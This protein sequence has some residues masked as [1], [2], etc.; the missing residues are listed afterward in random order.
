MK[1]QVL[2]FLIMLFVLTLSVVPL[3]AQV[4]RD[5]TGSTF[6]VDLT[7]W[8]PGSNTWIFTV[9][10]PDADLDGQGIDYIEVDFPVDVDVTT[11]T[12]FV[13]SVLPEVIPSDGTIGSTGITIKW[14]GADVIPPGG[15][16]TATI[17]A[18]IPPTFSGSLPLAWSVQGEAGYPVDPQ[19]IN[20]VVAL[21]Q[22]PGITNTN[23]VITT[24]TEGVDATT[25]IIGSEVVVTA[26]VTGEKAV[27]GVWV[28]MTAF[29]LGAIE[30]LSISRDGTYSGTFNVV[31]G[32][33]DAIDVQV[34]FS[35]ENST[36]E[37]AN[38]TDAGLFVV[39][40][41][42]PNFAGTGPVITMTG[43]DAIASI[44]D[45]LTFDTA[46]ATVV[47]TDAVEWDVAWAALTGS[48]GNVADGGSVDGAVIAGAVASS[49]NPNITATDDAGNTFTLTYG[50]IDADN[51]PPNVS[52]WGTF[53]LVNKDGSDTNTFAD[54]NNGT[55][56][57]DVTYAIGTVSSVA[58]GETWAVDY[59]GQFSGT[60]DP[61]GTVI[62]GTM[63]GEEWTPTIVVTDDAGNTNSNPNFPSG[64]L[65]D[66]QIPTASAIT[67]EVLRG[68]RA[69][70]T[71]TIGE[72]IRATVDITGMDVV[73]GTFDFWMLDPLAG[74]V[75]TNPAYIINGTVTATTIYAD[76]T[77]M[78]GD[79][80]IF[81]A[82]GVGV[83]VTLVDSADNSASM[84]LFGGVGNELYV[85][86]T[87]PGILDDLAIPS[88]DQYLRF[89]PESAVVGT[90]TDTPDVLNLTVGLENWGEPG[91]ASRFQL[92]IEAEDTREVV[93]Y[94][95]YLVADV[96]EAIPNEVT[97]SWDGMHPTTGL[98]LPNG[99]Y[100]L[101]LWQVTDNGSLNGVQGYVATIG[102]VDL[103]M[104]IVQLNAVHCVIDNAAP[105]YYDELAINAAGT[106]TPK[107][108]IERYFNDLNGNDIIDPGET[109]PIIGDYD[110]QF[111]FGIT[112]EFTQN[113]NP[114][115]IENLEYW[116]TV[117]GG[118]T[119]YF[120]DGAGIDGTP[121]FDQTADPVLIN[122]SAPHDVNAYVGNGGEI[123]WEPVD[124]ILWPAGDYT[125]TAYVQDTAGNIA[126]SAGRT[127]V[128]IT[129]VLYHQPILTN[130]EIISQHD[131]G[132]DPFTPM[133]AGDHNFYLNSN[134]TAVPNDQYYNT[135]DI[136]TV[137]ITFDD[138]EYLESVTINDDYGFGF[139]NLTFLPADFVGN[140][141]TVD[142]DVSTIDEGDAGSAYNFIDGAPLNGFE[143]IAR[144]EYLAAPIPPSGIEDLFNL[145]RPIEPV[146]P[147]AANFTLSMT[148]DRFSPGWYTHVY[149][150]Q[151]N[152]ATDGTLDETGIDFSMNFTGGLT[153]D[154]EW[155]LAVD[156][157][158]ID[159]PSRSAFSA[160]EFV[161]SGTVLSGGGPIVETIPTINFVGLKDDV[162][163][164]P[165]VGALDTAPLYVSAFATVVGD[166]SDTGYIV[167]PPGFT[168]TI[169]TKE[170]WVDNTNPELL[171][172]DGSALIDW[173][174]DANYAGHL[175]SEELVVSSSQD[176]LTIRFQTSEPIDTTDLSGVLTDYDGNNIPV[177][178]IITVTALDAEVTENGVTGH[179]HFAAFLDANGTIPAGTE[180]LEA[181]I[182][183]MI[184][185][186]SAGNPG[187]VNNPPY[188]FD[189]VAPYHAGSDA[190]RW[191]SSE[192]Y[193]RVM[194]LS[195]VPYIK[196]VRW[197]HENSYGRVIDNGNLT[198]EGYVSDSGT[199]T[200]TARINN[201]DYFPLEVGDRDITSIID[202]DFSIF[203][204]ESYENSATA[205]LM[206]SGHDLLV[207]WTD[208]PF[209]NIGALGDGT[210]IN[211]PF[212]LGLVFTA[213]E[214]GHYYNDHLELPLT[215]DIT[216]PVVNILDPVFVARRDV[217]L[218]EGST[219][220][221]PVEIIDNGSGVW[222]SVPPMTLT[223]DYS[224][225]GTLTITYD[226]YVA[227]DTYNWTVVVPENTDIRTVV[228]T[229]E[230]TDNVANL[231]TDIS[232]W[233]VG[234]V[235]LLEV[236]GFENTNPL[237]PNFIKNGDDAVLYISVRDIERVS[238]IDISLN[239]EFVYPV[240][241]AGYAATEVLTLTNAEFLA[242]PDAMIAVPARVD[243]NWEFKELLLGSINNAATL[244]DCDPVV[245]TVTINHEYDDATNA[246]FTTELSDES[247]LTVDN[248]PAT[249]TNITYDLA[250]INADAGTITFK[251]EIADM[252]EACP[253]GLDESTINLDLTGVNGDAVNAPDD[254]TLAGLAT[255][256]FAWPGDFDTNA[257]AIASALVDIDGIV[258]VSVDDNLGNSNSED[259][260][261]DTKPVITDV[262]WFVNN[263]ETDVILP[264]NQ[265]DIRVEVTVEGTDN[266]LEYKIGDRIYMEYIGA[267]L[268]TPITFGTPTQVVSSRDESVTFAFS[269]T[270]AFTA[271]M[272]ETG[273][274]TAEF[275]T[276]ALSMYNFRSDDVENQVVVSDYPREDLYGVE[277]VRAQD[278]YDGNDPTGWFA[279]EHNIRGEMTFYTVIEYGTTDV[280]ANFDYVGDFVSPWINPDVVNTVATEDI[281]LNPGTPFEVTITMLTQTAIWNEIVTDAQS[282]WNLII[283]AGMGYVNEGNVMDGFSLPIDMKAN[284]FGF[285]MDLPTKY[286]RVDLNDPAYS[287]ADGSEYYLEEDSRDFVPEVMAADDSFD[288]GLS[289]FQEDGLRAIVL[290][291][292]N[293][294]SS[295]WDPVTKTYTVELP[296][297]DLPFTQDFVLTTYA[298]DW[299]ST[300][301]YPSLGGVSPMTIE[302]PTSADFTIAPYAADEF[303]YLNNVSPNP[304]DQI[305]YANWVLTP[306][307]GGF[308]HGDE[309]TVQLGTITD[310][311][312]HNGGATPEFTFVFSAEYQNLNTDDLVIYKYISDSEPENA[313]IAPYVQAGAEFGIKLPV[314]SL[315]RDT[316][317]SGVDVFTAM[318]ENDVADTAAADLV[319]GSWWKNLTASSTEAGV[320][321]LDQQFS[322]YVIAPT[323]A[324]GSVLNVKLRVNYVNGSVQETGW[325]T[326]RTENHAI[327]DAIAP[328]I[329][330]Y[331]IEIWSETLTDADGTI[332][333]GYVVPGDNDATLKITFEDNTMMYP[334]GA[335]PL[336]EVAGLDQFITHYWIA[337]NDEDGF[338]EHIVMPALFTVPAEYITAQRGTWIAEIPRL[339][340]NPTNPVA[341]QEEILVSLW[342]AVGNAFIG[343]A[344]SKF[345]EITADGPIV[346]VIKGM[347]VIAGTP[348]DTDVDYTAFVPAADM[349]FDASGL[350]FNIAEGEDAP[351]YIN[352]YVRAKYKAYIE[353]MW[354]DLGN[355]GGD[356]V[357][358][359][360]PTEI[361]AVIDPVNNPDD[362]LW[363]ATYMMPNP[364]LSRATDVTITA[365]TLR[366]PF[367]A[368]DVFTDE[369]EVTLHVDQLDVVNSSLVVANNVPDFEV[370]WTFDPDFGFTV[371][372]EFDNI[373]GEFGYGQPN[374]SVWNI[375]RAQVQD[376]FYLQ[377][378][379]TDDLF[380]NDNAIEPK[381]S[382]IEFIGVNDTDAIPSII[383]N[384]D[385]VR[386]TW[387]IETADL[388]PDWADN[389]LY[390]AEDTAVNFDVHFRNIYGEWL[391][392]N[393]VDFNAAGILVDD[394]DPIFID[395]YTYG[396]NHQAN[397]TIVPDQDSNVYV[398]LE[399]TD[400]N[401][402]KYVTS[403]W[404][405]FDGAAALQMD[406]PVRAE[407]DFVIGYGPDVFN[408]DPVSMNGDVYITLTDNVGNVTSLPGDAVNTTFVFDEDETFSAY[409]YPDGSMI[410]SGGQ[411]FMQA[412]EMQ[413]FIEHDI[414]QHGSIQGFAP[415]ELEFEGIDNDGDF[416]TDEPGEGLVYDPALTI[417]VNSHVDNNWFE[418][419][420][421]LVDAA[422]TT[423]IELQG[424]FADLTEGAY[425]IHVNTDNIFGHNLD[426]TV[427]FFVDQTAPRVA[428]IRFQTGGTLSVPYAMNDVIIS[429]TD[430]DAIL[431]TFEDV[432]LADARDMVQPG[433][434]LDT[435][436]SSVVLEGPEGVI[437]G[438][439]VMSWNGNVAALTI[440]ADRWAGINLPSGDYTLTMVATDLLGNSATYTKTF[441]YNYT[442]AEVTLHIFDDNH[443]ELGAGDVIELSEEVAYI[444]A[445]VNDE[446][447]MVTDV[448][449]QLYF[450]VN[451]DNVLGPEDMEYT[452]IAG[453][454][455]FEV[456]FESTWNL[457][458]DDMTGAELIEHMNVYNYRHDEDTFN[459]NTRDWFIVTT[460][461][462]NSGQVAET[463]TTVMVRDNVG[464]AP[465]MLEIVPMRGM[466]QVES[467]VYN[468]TYNYD[469]M[470]DNTADL[471]SICKYDDDADG[472]VPDMGD[473]D[474][475][476][477]WYVNYHITGP[478]GYDVTI[479][480]SYMQPAAHTYNSIWNWG[481]LAVDNPGQYLITVTGHDRVGNSAD[482]LNSFVVNLATVG[483]AWSELAMTNFDVPNWDLTNPIVHGSEFG[484]VN[485]IQNIHN[486]R[487]DAV[488]HEM[489]EVVS[490]GFYYDVIDNVTGLEVSTMNP[491][492]NDP[493]INPDFGT[494]LTNILPQEVNIVGNEGTLRVVVDE[495]QYR[496]VGY[497]ANDYS[498]KFYI[499]ITD[500]SGVPFIHGDSNVVGFRVDYVA[501]AANM[502]AIDEVLTGVIDNVTVVVP[503][504]GNAA[505]EFGF[506]YDFV[507]LDHILNFKWSYDGISWNIFEPLANN[508][509]GTV[510]TPSLVE[511]T[512]SFNDWDTYVLDA[513]D[514]TNLE[515]NVWVTAEVQDVRGNW[516]DA[517]PTQLYVDNQAPDVPISQVSYRGT[518]EADGVEPSLYQDWHDLGTMPNE[519]DNTI[520]VAYNQLD[521]P[522]DGFLRVRVHQ[523]DILDLSTAGIMPGMVNDLAT[524][525]NLYH[526]TGDDVNVTVSNDVIAFDHEVDA[527]GYYFF[528]ILLD[529]SYDPALTHYFAFIGEDS[530]VPANME[531]DTNHNGNIGVA[532][533]DVAWD[534]KVN[535]VNDVPVMTEIV[536][537]MSQFVGEWI[538]L[539]AHEVLGDYPPNETLESV[540]FQVS[541]DTH[542][543]TDLGTV[544]PA[545]AEAPYFFHLYRSEVPMFDNMPF[546]PGIHVYEGMNQIGELVWNGTDAWEATIDMTVGPHNVM[547]VAD[548]ND[549]GIVDGGEM[550]GAF[551]HPNN[552]GII[553]IAPYMLAYNT[554]DARLADGIY[555]FRAVPNADPRGA[556]LMPYFID[557]TAPV[558]TIDIEGNDEAMP[559]YQVDADVALVTDID[560]LL[561]NE[562]DLI[563]V[564]YQFSAQAPEAELRQWFFM[565]DTNNLPGDF[566]TTFETPDPLTDDIDNDGD[567]YVDEV[568]EANAT[569]YVRSYAYDLAGNY[570]YS[571]EQ[572]MIVD[573][574]VAMM[575]LS[576]IDGVAM[577]GANAVINIPEDGMV[578]L[579]ATDI[580]PEYLDG[581]VSADFYFVDVLNVYT[582][583]NLDGAVEVVD[584]M[585]TA[586][587]NLDTETRVLLAEGY[588]GIA[589]IATDRVE[590]VQN[591]NDAIITPIILNDVTGPEAYITSVGG[592]TMVG[593]GMYF[594]NEENY[595]GI[596]TV[597]YTNPEDVATITVEYSVDGTIWHNIDTVNMNRADLQVEWTL[598]SELDDTYML[599]ALVEDYQ[600]NDTENIAT[601]YYDNELPMVDSTQ[602]ELATVLTLNDIPVLDV[603]GDSI[604]TNITYNVDG[605]HGML[606][607]ADVK[608]RLKPIANR[609]NYLLGRNSYLLPGTENDMFVADLSEAASDEYEV[610]VTVTDFAGNE[611]IY[612][613]GY[614]VIDQTAPMFDAND[615]VH[616]TDGMYQMDWYAVSNGDV[617]EFTFDAAGYVDAGVQPEND[618]FLGVETATLM[619][620]GDEVAE[621]VVGTFDIDG[622]IMF[623]WTP[624][625]LATYTNEEIAMSMTLTDYY[626]N[627]TTVETNAMFTLLDT[628]ASI[629]RIL[630]VDD[631]PVDWQ[632]DEANVMASGNAA[633]IDAYVPVSMDMAQLVRF[634][635]NNAGV[636]DTLATVSAMATA[637]NAPY[638]YPTSDKFTYTWDLSELE[639]GTHQIRAIAIDKAGQE[640]ANPMLVNVTLNNNMDY[641]MAMVWSGADAATELV[642][643]N[644]Y[645]L[646]ATSAYPEMITAIEWFYRYADETG[647]FDNDVWYSIGVDADTEHPYFLNDWLISNLMIPGLNIQI[648]AVPTYVADVVG[649]P[650]DALGMFELGNFVEL[651]VVDLT[652]PVIESL[653]FFN[654]GRDEG[655]GEDSLI[656]MWINNDITGMIQIVRS[657]ISAEYPTLE[658]VEMSDLHRIVLS[659]ST[660][661]R[662]EQVL[663]EIQFNNEA[664][665]NPYEY[666]Y[667]NSGNGWDISE[668][669][670][671]QYEIKLTA[672]DTADNM[673]ELAMP[674][675]IDTEAPVTALTITD[676]DGNDV[677]YLE[678]DVTY[679]LNANAT[680]N[681]M[682]AGY[683]YTYAYNNTVFAIEGDTLQVEFTV[684]ANTPYGAEL[685]FEVVATD[686][687]GLDHSSSVAKLVFDA[688]TT[689]ITITTV[690]GTAYIPGLHINGDVN[691]VASVLGNDAPDYINQV[692]FMYRF[693]GETEWML[694]DDEA[695]VVAVANDMATDN[696]DTT[697]L[698]EGMIEVGAVPVAD[699]E[700]I[701]E[702][703]MYWATME[704]DQT[705]PVMGA[706]VVVIPTN[707]NGTEL[708]VE[709]AEIPADLNHAAVRFEYAVA[710]QAG[711]PEAWTT[712]A[713][714]PTF[715]F[716]GGM[717]AFV[718]EDVE[719]VNS[720]MYDFRL[721]TADVT[722]PTPNTGVVNNIEETDA[723]TLYDTV[724]PMVFLS[725]IDGNIAPFDGA[726]EVVL[727][728]EMSLTADAFEHVE[729][730]P[731]VSG[732]DYVEFYVVNSDDEEF[733]LGMAE[734]APYTILASTMGLL[735]GNYEVTAVAYDNA[736]NETISAIEI[737]RII[738]DIDPIAYIAGFDFDNENANLDHI[739]AVTKDCV[740]A[741]SS[742]VNFEYTID[743]MNW[744]TFATAETV[745]IVNGV[746]L[747]MA[748]FN[749]NAMANV[750]QLRAMV[751]MANDEYTERFA[752]L[753]VTYSDAMG[754]M[755]EFATNEDVVIY[756]E[757]VVDIM[758]ADA[759]PFLLGMNEVM[760]NGQVSTIELLDPIQMADG[761]DHFTA[762]ITIHNIDETY[763]N[764]ITVW[765][766]EVVENVITLEKAEL[767]VYPVTAATGTN[768]VITS[769]NEMMM[770]N[771]PMNSGSGYVYFQPVH[772]NNMRNVEYQAITGQEALL[773]MIEYPEMAH[774]AMTLTGDYNEEGVVMA[775]FFDG[776]DWTEIDSPVVVE[777]G[778]AMFDAVPNMG[779][780]MVVQAVSPEL[781]VD[782]VNVSNEWMPNGAVWTQFGGD[783]EVGGGDGGE[784]TSGVQFTFRTFINE[785]GDNYEVDT[786]AMIDIYLDDVKVVDAGVADADMV[787][788]DLAIDP[789]SGLF[790]VVLN[791]EE[792]LSDEE[793]HNIRA[794]VYM[795]G[796]SAE[797]DVDFYVDITAPAVANDGGGYVRHG[798][799]ISATITDP[800]TGIFEESLGLLLY[801]PE[802]VNNPEE[803][804]FIDYAS[805]EVVEV[806]NGYTV[807]YQLTLDDLATVLTGTADMNEIYAEWSAWNNV[808]MLTE[809]E[810]NTVVYVVDVAAPVVWAVSPVGAPLDNDGDGLFNEDPING[811]NEDLDFDDWNNNNV[812]DGMWVSDSSGT[813][814]VGE[815][816]LIDEDPIDFLP[817]TLMY[818]QDVVIAVAYED[819]PMPTM[820]DGNSIYSGASGV[821]V[822][823]IVVTLNGEIMPNDAAT[824]TAGSWQIANNDIP[825]LDEDGNL[826]P[827]HYVI[828]ASVPDMAGNIGVVNYE[829]EV[830]SP[831][832]TVE[833]MAFEDAGWWFTQAYGEAVNFV[834]TVNETAGI[835]VAADGVVAS[836]YSV[837]SGALVQGPMTLASTIDPELGEIYIASLGVVLPEDQT[838]VRLEVIATNVLGGQS[839]GNQT[840]SVD[841]QAPAITFVTP[842]NGETF[843][844]NDN[845][846]IYA[847]YEDMMGG[848]V[849][850]V[851][852]SKAISSREI[853]S[854]INESSSYLVIT[855]PD[856]EI[857][858][859]ISGG[860][861][862]IDFTIAS[863]D[864]M[865]GTYQAKVTVRD[866][867]GNEA[868]SAVQF[869]VESS[870]PS[871]TFYAL[872]GYEGTEVWS[873][874]PAN[875]NG[876]FTFGVNCSAPLADD[877]VVVSFFVGETLIQGPQTLVEVDGMYSVNLGGNIPANADGVKLQVTATNTYNEVS[878]SSQTYSIDATAP[879]VTFESPE[880]GEAFG[881]EMINVLV[882]YNDNV[883]EERTGLKASAIT[884]EFSMTANKDIRTGIAHAEL[885]IYDPEGT[886]IATVPGN[887][888][889]MSHMFMP[890]ATG[891]YHAMAT[892]MDMVGNQTVKTIQF[893]V[894]AA[895]LMISFQPFANA[896]WYYGPNSN[897]AFSFMVSGDVAANGVVVNFYTPEGELLQGPQVVNGTEGNYSVNLAYVPED[898]VAVTLEVKATNISGIQTVSSQVYQ[899]DAAAPIVEIVAPAANSM[900]E[901]NAGEETIVNII[902]NLMDDGAGI[903]SV[904][905]K[906]NNQII[907][908]V[909]DGNVITA[910]DS[911]GVG[912]Y[913]AEL[914]VTDNAANTA[915]VS[916]SFSVGAMGDEIISEAH[917][918]PN[919]G[920]AGEGVTFGISFAR[921]AEVEVEIFDW[922]GNKVRT[923][924][925]G[926]SRSVMT[927]DTRS[928]SGMTVARG[929]YFARVKANDGKKVDEKIVK[930][931]IKN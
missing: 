48:N 659:Y 332:E 493:V 4:E 720:Q 117:E 855:S 559:I 55:D 745:E 402:V 359:I 148:N 2:L 735:I 183:V 243:L 421:E 361:E 574:S 896:G 255:W 346:P 679:L 577:V 83:D 901:V 607:V 75:G 84:A 321:F 231:N 914:T 621:T 383:R 520:T 651:G 828:I 458:N 862:S 474:W 852:G 127:I 165:F 899:I 64:I 35:A 73:S 743:G 726:V 364:Q 350:E 614:Y 355:L 18:D 323:Y 465:L 170:F 796:Y 89:S 316:A 194:L 564:V 120:Y 678:R 660:P 572:A 754:G 900:I 267:L 927:W 803:Q 780:Y 777:D 871:V 529:D 657:E 858:D 182:V 549:N 372:A 530:R 438:F 747:W 580:T 155:F 801:N 511:K 814:W 455:D 238:S 664:D 354:L 765:S 499:M 503:A 807:S 137:Q 789:I 923:L 415:D 583:I 638:E 214:D 205:F 307:A 405:E 266:H 698:A 566:G 334:E 722:I 262:K 703:P 918:Y 174:G 818:A 76:Y 528:D 337:D 375:T 715:S 915:I 223:S 742:E 598:P 521:T 649:D 623:A 180:F 380:V 181:V 576:A 99:N 672:W 412:P 571:A 59:T 280:I 655:E 278:I 550:A 289:W 17:T 367:G 846:Q 430:W 710:D 903:A 632:V 250:R 468:F 50:A 37:V 201:V 731:L 149:D 167:E 71:A 164:D 69:A 74:G 156:T 494:D 110:V 207:T 478:N 767:R 505:D 604:R 608:I 654:N 128:T 744:T 36:G 292:Y 467:G 133:P 667:T 671:G 318:L 917:A 541:E 308:V 135:D 491:L 381:I 629:A 85:D 602:V 314:A 390:G 787:A 96:T 857:S 82:P 385:H 509:D 910:T 366:H 761:S 563:E 817:D 768:G 888:Q 762:P 713:T 585:A 343:N 523:D 779:I 191:D 286:I 67:F 229:A 842:E 20:G 291:G 327:V 319:A 56:A 637:V 204:A 913:T 411:W 288:L 107:S 674:F 616:V 448:N 628:E 247:W 813:H 508:G 305:Y 746:E 41:Q 452:H 27:D 568:D 836:F 661:E 684:P 53:T 773:G 838:G 708:R 682:V 712:L 578:E 443:V 766:T 392:G 741:P 353:E 26:E 129:D 560:G 313:A 249:I 54:L 115:R 775:M 86:G 269:P 324:D 212:D 575:H 290:D 462:S 907:E 427:D 219:Y 58:D 646:T 909:I 357:T 570:G 867:V 606:D 831:A 890:A 887:A 11:S 725:E 552:T 236:T 794:Y 717:Y 173:D 142:Y 33:V 542:N 153:Q 881:T 296:Y 131:D 873:F 274:L 431:V 21:V 208:V 450:D 277:D 257:L 823:N 325:V 177:V 538:N 701:F 473:P 594:A 808:N 209:D 453:T 34:T 331:G 395:A 449:F 921:D 30:Y 326:A 408:L 500:Y 202:A 600:G 727:G 63:N 714:A 537:P 645:N 339:E 861:S 489:D 652:A 77:I 501:P 472:N 102:D 404:S 210:V 454:P 232:T 756:N 119:T 16:F 709:F 824:I 885:V 399:Y 524:P 416:L 763:G 7:T 721:T 809:E 561:V 239:T 81:I 707:I 271:D 460:V 822:E 43:G 90:F 696:L 875:N 172:E 254:F 160:A 189:N 215:I 847:T 497:D 52:D 106:N 141:L 612:N 373:R 544:L 377:N 891:T 65:V 261:V 88:S 683:A 152:P 45:V 105:I 87:L 459:T 617:I 653:S 781:N 428:G 442:P 349:A 270:L 293:Y 252:P 912:T 185:Q 673:A 833:F 816:S 303:G 19:G 848:V 785:D 791:N 609:A 666:N 889:S 279:P 244:V 898:M 471:V 436:N 358:M 883:I 533:F 217:D 906:L 590:N 925:G 240:S 157:E 734:A 579:T 387:K 461:N 394:Q 630:E 464:P 633:I 388:N 235:P 519:L 475:P 134:F 868:V 755:F 663:E 79:N 171:T 263:N 241:R 805:M 130:V 839:T 819:I 429:Y 193:A 150:S 281:T 389:L 273:F 825:G 567:G 302:M 403:N 227:P 669:V 125:V 285:L 798:M 188:P 812:Q 586:M 104:G 320:W 495:D 874:N 774:F 38:V 878:I 736:G 97:F 342:D 892:V 837:P 694:F 298:S 417:N 379:G 92:R 186:D 111:E 573:G 730:Y 522:E 844:I 287:N 799:S 344:A 800:E 143:I 376:W 677:D 895:E 187:R 396:E 732:I 554:M 233:D 282:I 397:Q 919:P 751:V 640:D 618:S 369:F 877:G 587:W 371:V 845:V 356:A 258:T 301:E 51:V 733:M 676:V 393:S 506:G 228:F 705:A 409:V 589:V 876:P 635:L 413:L 702:V 95:D 62:A 24:G 711:I 879:T 126:V 322:N 485:P 555:Y 498:Y 759:E 853:G 487:L 788:A 880:A 930:I 206:A 525:I 98:V 108:T 496:G 335:V 904:V 211:V 6:T 284:F 179:K 433:V 22:A 591:M 264:D 158:E 39:D 931:A 260:M 3:S 656:D 272:P 778:V 687:V 631:N 398:H 338:D 451:N 222:D 374:G 760:N 872:A 849:A 441:F 502:L 718:L 804:L 175:Y 916:V 884:K 596:I 902:A 151:S 924:T 752:T 757:D 689:E 44:G 12:D 435:A 719:L 283:P 145:I 197:W 295:N 843:G 432:L 536:N 8:S 795:A 294:G 613:Y 841:N 410:E 601:F 166:F 546:V 246:D 118:S 116:F 716:N 482:G 221:V 834:F 517:T 748:P 783:V 100:G 739:Y 793:M 29:E 479:G 611:A 648:V 480:N 699:P 213:P 737:V 132:L 668:F 365:H 920:I 23:V 512:Y 123:T 603:R 619:L 860:L 593:E 897:E 776:T 639:N 539:A 457:L 224:G 42:I 31:A 556:E 700:N 446:F 595:N 424:Q 299:T 437:E 551:V 382:D 70:Q 706:P 196:N 697:D 863:G 634:E 685:L 351:I 531:A 13:S 242:L 159:S 121:A 423:L 620:T 400:V 557:N 463:T 348:M 422:G 691:Y 650:L 10:N 248:A 894:N 61:T 370:E 101:T 386:V 488:I 336:L 792:Y 178:P 60:F 636:W 330:E 9:T 483:T 352:V 309:V 265:L 147:D 724:A 690:A 32:N 513:L 103:P 203:G 592:R 49:T 856:G 704:I 312:G 40:N 91:G 535:L 469:S 626:N 426:T 276:F 526:G 72:T 122:F 391:I 481:E 922:A 341:T 790:Y 378:D 317:I 658:N 66:N 109:T 782:F 466:V 545:V 627:A 384:K 826:T 220:T 597:A 315:D 184:D 146:W 362:N 670:N 692:A 484:P 114:L 622:N 57:D 850:S 477:A 226:A 444:G 588:Y 820:V 926:N 401:E 753:N 854:G 662:S 154:I 911:L 693:V 329:V 198:D 784:R 169:T 764:M 562:D 311:V 237:A 445:T 859:P 770:L 144:D 686:M 810:T 515:G 161:R 490:L 256:E 830:I 440:E 740:D 548:M 46:A 815:P 644:M 772:E 190:F 28:D 176:T 771:I 584:G 163:A 905:V 140:V 882:T 268:G 827:G 553:E 865:V 139:G 470:Y 738:S 259:L 532:E 216:E 251:A 610:L 802:D 168:E 750:L 434:G 218:L 306:P 681:M 840:Y 534:L 581:A 253:A 363:V 642:R 340:V 297:A 5:I 797:V 749:A 870:A 476:D 425:T 723:G 80:D 605:N 565:D 504:L 304:D 643:G 230:A 78:L 47:G 695:P 310:K 893:S 510:E 908:S 275:N 112:R 769:E 758:S 1:K 829:F 821:D 199:F 414:M 625:T 234:N 300:N 14:D 93:G 447:G 886:A 225:I 864:L 811:I 456:P 543:W 407:E 851:R 866:N 420:H 547:L 368:F 624:D 245:A 94:V 68:D 138:I 162:T 439:D 869:V 665:A 200:I 928:E 786:A 15:I 929:V 328:T 195:Q 514:V 680:D 418:F 527:N 333:E 688:D 641:P 615:L 728:T 345:V 540:T 507:G 360:A 558:A 582:Q 192:A 347:E 518:V 124:P 835:A 136:L 25:A 647:E 729:E 113:T 419:P 492:M 406:V 675:Y 516:A 832:P 486:L 599:R 806:E 569:Y